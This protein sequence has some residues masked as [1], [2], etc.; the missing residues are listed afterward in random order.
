VANLRLAEE[1]LQAAKHISL[2]ENADVEILS[3]DG[4][5]TLF[6]KG[7]DATPVWFAAPAPQVQAG[8]PIPYADLTPRGIRLGRWMDERFVSTVVYPVDRFLDLYRLSTRRS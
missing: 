1:V 2:H 3:A 4:A 5:R 7:E 8:E 6:V